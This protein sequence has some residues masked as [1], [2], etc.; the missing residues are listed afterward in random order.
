MLSAVRSWPEAALV[1]APLRTHVSPRYLEKCADESARIQPASAVRWDYRS[2]DLW[3]WVFAATVAAAGLVRRGEFRGAKILVGC[4]ALL[5][6]LLGALP[7]FNGGV[8]LDYESL[9]AWGDTRN[10][11][12]AGSVVLE[13]SVFLAGTA[14]GFVALTSSSDKDKDGSE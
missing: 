9:P 10:L 6:F 13:A 7:V 3:F 12:W 11:R 2:W 5:A 14:L 8:F 4:T 1:N